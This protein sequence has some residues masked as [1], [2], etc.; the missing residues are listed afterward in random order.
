[1]NNIPK[2]IHLI[3]KDHNIPTHYAASFNSIKEFH[4]NWDIKIYSDEA[5]RRIVVEQMP[6]LTTVY[7]GYE[8]DIQR[9]DLFRLVVVYLY[10]GFYMDLDMLCLQNIDQL[11]SNRLV[12][13]EEKMMTV[14]ECRSIGLRHPL[15]IAN[16]MFGSV[17]GH[18]FWLDVI[19][20]VVNRAGSRVLNEN[21]VLETTG[22]GLL[23]DVFHS[24]KHKYD[25]ITLLLNK[26]KQCRKWC[27]KI[28]CHFGEYAAHL[29]QGK[30][31]WQHVNNK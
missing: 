27:G 15:R 20:E 24:E 2:R 21:D 22:P 25:D 29:H 18:A 13:G 23:T 3:Y 28:S 7:D 26:D 12:L 8:L 14:E 19:K 11:C 17:A 30:W 10:G 9:A 16:Y 4:K 5:A 6:G 1:M 31:R